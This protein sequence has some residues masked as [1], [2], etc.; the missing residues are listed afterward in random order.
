MHRLNE[1]SEGRTADSV[2]LQLKVSIGTEQPFETRAAPRESEMRELF[3][4][5]VTTAIV[6]AILALATF[7]TV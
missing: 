5:V 6:A 4:I 2:L 3:R 7:L 1:V